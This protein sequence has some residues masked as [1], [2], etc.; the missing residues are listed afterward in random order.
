[1]T[2]ITSSSSGERDATTG[3]FLS[4][5]NGGPGRALGQRSRLGEQFLADLRETWATHG[6]SALE[7]CAIEDPVQFCRIVAGLLPRQAELDVSMGFDVAGF[8][9]KF[10][11]A[12]SLLDG[13]DPDQAQ[14]IGR[15]RIKVINHE[16]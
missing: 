10:R 4:G 6:S 7:R 12:V 14:P 15:H 2:S 13:A 5:N 1:M 16:R 3:R 11:A 9:E 8:A